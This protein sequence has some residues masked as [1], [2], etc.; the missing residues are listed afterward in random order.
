ME[1]CTTNYQGLIPQYLLLR[2]F[3]WSRG[4]RRLN[5]RVGHCFERSHGIDPALLTDPLDSQPNFQP[6]GGK[7][8]I[9]RDRVIWDGASRA[10][11]RVGGHYKQISYSRSLLGKVGGWF[12]GYLDVDWLMVEPPFCRQAYLYLADHGCSA[13][14]Q[15]HPKS[16]QKFIMILGNNRPPPKLADHWGGSALATVPRRQDFGCRKGI[17]N[18]TR[19]RVICNSVHTTPV[20]CSDDLKCTSRYSRDAD[21]LCATSFCKGMKS[22]LEWNPVEEV[23][24]FFVALVARISTPCRFKAYPFPIFG[25]PSRLTYCI[26]GSRRC[27]LILMTEGNK[28]P[29]DTTVHGPST[30]RDGHESVL[31]FRA[32]DIFFFLLN[33]NASLVCIALVFPA[34]FCVLFHREPLTFFHLF[35]ICWDCFFLDGQASCLCYWS[36]CWRNQ[37]WCCIFAKRRGTVL[38]QNSNDVRHSVRCRDCN[39]CYCSGCEYI[40]RSN[41]LCQ[42]WNY[43][44]SSL[45]LLMDVRYS[46]C[47]AH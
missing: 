18:T 42:D 20:A 16:I 46:Q 9:E 37:Y 5:W 47:S 25:E 36:W 33:C 11:H 45:F 7:R 14:G 43:S 2:P 6:K 29:R 38:A 3:Y 22:T 15:Y 13:T 30:K 39:R 31:P 21:R 32:Y 12:Q 10:Q 24:P 4:R 23:C 40:K 35:K 19:Q 17:F 41:R 1:A 26:R 44:K 27:K 34:T 28:I 8:A